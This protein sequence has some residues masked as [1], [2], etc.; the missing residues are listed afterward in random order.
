MG[1][2]KRVGIIGC[3]NI[4]PA[5]LKHARLY[6]FLRIERL[7]DLD[8]AR[9][10]ACAQEH[11]I[12][13]GG[14]VAALLSDDAIEVVVNLTIPA[15]HAEV[16]L[17]ALNAGKHVYS[18]KPLSISLDDGRRILASAES[19]GLRAGCAPDTFLGSGGQTCRALIESGAIG[20]P[21]GALAFF[22]NR[23]METWH[24]N[25]AFF[26][27]RG[28]G[29]MMDV[30]VYYVTALV[31]LLGPIR[32]VTGSARISFPEREITSEPLKGQR[33]KVET[34]TTI[35]GTM[36][37]ERGPVATMVA[38][39]D[40]CASEVPRIE[41]FGTEG[42]LSVPDPNRFDG[43]VR[44]FRRSTGEWEDVS[45]VVTTALGRGAGLADM[46]QAIREDRAHRCSGELALHVLEAMLAFELASEQ[47]RHV[48]LQSSCQQPAPM[49]PARIDGRPD[50][51]YRRRQLVG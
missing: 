31:N 33:L 30:G 26:Y 41:V 46:V 40:V 4:L 18:E 21:V 2:E 13:H 7:A 16:S 17:A 43:A 42:T 10:Q 6:D 8:E 1:A 24:P 19:R 35:A 5:Y 39:N 49:A 22:L 45:P 25:P 11:G 12:P 48:Q 44:L 32:R 29:P 9:A 20:E 51:E 50:E 27:Q 47:G 3:G 36:D 38:S 14:S 28:A 15:A 37:F 34:P 23:G